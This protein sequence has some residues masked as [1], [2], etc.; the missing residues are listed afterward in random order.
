[1]LFRSNGA[2]VHEP[3]TGIMQRFDKA[4]WPTK[5]ATDLW[6]ALSEESHAK[7]YVVR[8]VQNVS[9][10]QNFP[11]YALVLPMLYTKDDLPDLLELKSYI[12]RF[13]EILRRTNEK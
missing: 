8:M 6:K 7:K 9:K 12:A 1:M 5:H 11:S 2:R 3:V 13:S 4:L 10:R